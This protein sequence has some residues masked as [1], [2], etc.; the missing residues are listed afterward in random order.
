V[1]VAFR[2]VVFPAEREPEMVALPET[3]VCPALKAPETVLLPVTAR[4]LEVAPMEIR[5]PK[6][7]RLE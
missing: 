4:A 3:V 7:P 5:F 1:V 2:R 6:L